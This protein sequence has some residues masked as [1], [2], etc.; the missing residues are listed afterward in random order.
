MKVLKSRF[1]TAGWKSWKGG[2]VSS[3]PPKIRGELPR[4]AREQNLSQILKKLN[5]SKLLLLFLRCVK[6]DLGRCCDT[7]SLKAIGM[8][9]H[10]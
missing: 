6:D 7:V 3:L 10:K 2:F 9:F 4:A 1:W 5:P 8:L